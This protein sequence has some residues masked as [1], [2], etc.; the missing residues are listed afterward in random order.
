MHRNRFSLGWSKAL[1][2]LTLILT[3]ATDAGAVST[4][5][6]LYTFTGG[7][8]GGLP[9]AGLIMDE[10]GNLYGTA[11]G[12]G[13]QACGGNGCGTVFELTPK[14]PGGWT[15]TVLYSFSGGSDGWDPQAA[16]ISDS[17]GNLYGVALQ[18][19][20]S[21]CTYTLG[22]GTVF[23]LSPN[24]NGGWTETT[25]YRFIGGSDGQNPH[26]QLIFDKAGHLYGTTFYGGVPSCYANV[27]CGTI[28]ELTPNADGWTETVLH[29]FTGGNDGA[30]VRGGLILDLDEDKLFG[31]TEQGGGT[32]C[33]SRGC[34]TIFSLSP[35]KTGW[36]ERVVYRFTGASDGAFP[37]AGLIKDVSGNLY[38]TT[39]EGGDMSCSVPGGLG[40]C[41][42]V[43]KMSLTGGS[44]KQT[45]LY[46]FAAERNGNI[47]VDSVI[48]YKGN[49]YGT[50]YQGGS[51][52]CYKGQGCGAVF[53][54]R[55]TKAG[56]AEKV[57]HSF[58]ARNDGEYPMGSLMVDQ[59][60][61]LY[62]TT[63]NNGGAYGYGDVF[64]VTP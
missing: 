33:Y 17:K 61:N 47:P 23:K 51:S 58:T 34:G 57:L 8:D 40:G 46:A 22:C 48:L 64:E 36:T 53:E 54:L 43:F 45:V 37:E 5:K 2:I 4:E 11:S 3:L 15:E 32:G 52:G 10:S 59:I 41:G 35:S 62:G 28:F 44:W 38:G 18:G 13:S 24:G 31:T 27:G 39:A 1:P 14:S 25:L 19:G 21:A 7:S 6:V 50:T 16:L 30:F 12:G 26:A 60:G 56:W 9:V 49:L 20:S 42:A 63:A 29:R 55:H